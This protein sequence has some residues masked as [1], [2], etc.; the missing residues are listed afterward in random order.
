MFLMMIKNFITILLRIK[1][2]QPKTF[3]CWWN[4]KPK[5]PIQRIH[6]NW[7]L[8]HQKTLDKMFRW[9]SKNW[10]VINWALNSKYTRPKW[11]GF[12]LQQ[13]KINNCVELFSIPFS[14]DASANFVKWWPFSKSF[15]LNLWRKYQNKL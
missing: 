11:M 15:P 6:V 2:T 14:F 3:N 9:Y 8:H 7:K 5:S 12:V 10:N 1:S 4:Q 13:L